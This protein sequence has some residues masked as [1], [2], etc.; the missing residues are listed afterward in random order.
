MKFKALF[1]VA[2]LTA[3][4]MAE[5]PLEAAFTIKNGKVVD[6]SSVA[7]R[8]LEEHWELG[9]RAIADDEWEEA[10]YQFK[11]IT[12]SFPG[13]AHADDAY[14][15]LGVSYFYMAEYDHANEAL[16]TYLKCQTSPRYFQEV[17]EYKFAIADRLARGEKRRF[18]GTKRLPKWACGKDLAVEIY[19]EVIA[20][21]PCLEIAGQALIAKGFLLWNMRDYKAAVESFQMG[22]RRFPKTE[23]APECYVWISKVYVEQSF[24]EF[25]NPDILAFAEINLARF[26]KDFPRDESIEEV[27]NDVKD[28]KEIYA[29]GLYNTGQFY[30]RTKHRRAAIIYYHNAIHQFPDTCT[31]AL[32][33]ERLICI[34]ETYSA[35]ED[36]DCEESCEEQLEEAEP[37]SQGVIEHIQEL[38]GS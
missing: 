25:Q 18:F 8:S 36:D 31:A 32:C 23:L 28:I 14:Y 9:A 22:I 2:C 17:I 38:S 6:A 11:I 20:A 15:F 13:S 10:A 37:R 26:E 4:L 24:Y 21:V 34:D 5:V 29:S 3:I 19:D 16:T 30:E 35:P 27:K 33:I 1:V 12:Y 7:T